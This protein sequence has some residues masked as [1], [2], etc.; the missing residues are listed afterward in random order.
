[1]SN[2]AKPQNKGAFQKNEDPAQQKH[3]ADSHGH[4]KVHEV[5]DKHQYFD[6][7]QEKLNPADKQPQRLH[8]KDKAKEVGNKQHHFT[9]V[10]YAKH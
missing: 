2:D 4:D 10:D 5:P 1:M 7:H 3:H 9:N 8:A 6:K